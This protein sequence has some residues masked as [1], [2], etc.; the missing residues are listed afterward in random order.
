[1]AQ[2]IRELDLRAVWESLSSPSP[3][4][5]GPSMFALISRKCTSL[6]SLALNSVS[7]NRHAS[8]STKSDFAASSWSLRSLSIRDLG[9]WEGGCQVSDVYHIMSFF[10]RVKSLHLD[11]E[12]LYPASLASLPSFSQLEVD[13]LTIIG[14]SHPTGPVVFDLC[15]AICASRTSHSLNRLSVAVYYS[16]YLKLLE[17]FPGKCTSLKDITLNMREYMRM[18]S[19]SYHLSIHCFV[20]HHSQ[21]HPR[22]FHHS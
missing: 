6:Q 12:V 7:W 1:M 9:D 22:P 20:A 21:V 17:V 8:T 2:Y 15:R 4:R 11:L 3:Q 14:P 5:V 18:I 10:T 16:E 13:S 19:Q